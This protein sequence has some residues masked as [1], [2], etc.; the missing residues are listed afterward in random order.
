MNIGAYPLLF[1]TA[2][3]RT[4]NREDEFSTRLLNVLVH[5]VIS[6][7]GDTPKIYRKY[8]NFN[9]SLNKKTTMGM[10]PNLLETSTPTTP[11][12]IMTARGAGDH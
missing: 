7:V 2:T 11:L 8:M 3:Q 10:L 5:L 1:P 12:Q 4:S 9:V 6:I